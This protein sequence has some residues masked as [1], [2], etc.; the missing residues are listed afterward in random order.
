MTRKALVCR[1]FGTDAG[2][3]SCAEGDQRARIWVLAG[4]VFTRRRRDEAVDEERV[5]IDLQI[6][7]GECARKM[8]EGV[9]SRAEK[10]AER[11]ERL[12]GSA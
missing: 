2:I 11:E 6:R 10:A 7:R 5:V 3:G 9:G 8:I 4:D 12:V 1:R